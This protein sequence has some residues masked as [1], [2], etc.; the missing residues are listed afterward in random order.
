MTTPQ[1]QAQSLKALRDYSEW[2]GKPPVLEI[3][4]AEIER[5]TAE[6][7]HATRAL[8]HVRQQA[9]IW[10]QEANTQRAAVIGVGAALGGL[11]DYGPIVS[12]VEAM[13]AELAGLKAAELTDAEL[14]KIARGVHGYTVRLT[15]DTG[16]YDVAEPTEVFRELARAIL[17]AGRAD[18]LA[19]LKAAG[20][21]PLK[22]TPRR[23]EYVK[24]ARIFALA[25]GLHD[26]APAYLPRTQDEADNFTPHGWVI[27]AMMQA[28]GD[29]WADGHAAGIEFMKLAAA[30][31]DAQPAAPVV[32]G[33][34]PI[35]TLPRVHGEVWLGWV[36]YVK[37]HEDADGNCVT[38]DLS[39]VDFIEWQ[40]GG[41]HHDGYWMALAGPWGDYS[42]GITHGMPLPS[43]PAPKQEQP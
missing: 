9:S 4:A 14:L 40:A 34:Q 29:G 25:Y 11:P 35:E 6:L 26:D 10:H 17:A 28:F 1:P 43:A 3:A 2:A 32:A 27:A 15:K 13:A 31:A 23:D 7:A 24:M 22:G 37:N 5:L 16:P 19:G 39:T 20:G 18:Q 8:E 30:R 12:S 33:W 38:Q 42:D 41:E 36:H 21:E